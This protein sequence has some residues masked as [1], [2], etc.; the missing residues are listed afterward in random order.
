MTGGLSVRD[1]TVDFTTAQGTVRACSRVSFDVE[2]GTRLAI[3]GESG[4]GKTTT[5]LALLGM[6][7][8]SARVASG[9]A[10]LGGRDILKLTGEV[11]RTVRLAE[12][13]YVPQGAMNSLNP[14]LRIQEQILHGFADH[15]RRLSAR[16]GDSRIAELLAMVGLAPSVAR[17]FPHQLSGG[18]KQRVCIAI[19]AS[20]RPGLLIADEPTS[21]LDVITQRQVMEALAAS[22]RALGSGM[23]LIAHDVALVGQFADRVLVLN[24][25]EV[26]EAGDV[27]DV[28]SAPRQAYTR[29]LIESVPRLGAPGPA[30]LERTRAAGRAPLL[31]FRSV[32]KSYAGAQ[33]ASPALADLSFR[34]SGDP[35]GVLAVVGQSGSG[36]T[37]LASLALGL[38]APDQGVIRYL[39]QPLADLRGQ[40]RRDFRREVQAVFQDPYAA[41]NPFYRVGRALT[42]PLRRFGAARSRSHAASLA[43]S[44]CAEVG[45]DPDAVLRR[46]PHEL[47]G[48]QRQRLMVARALALRPR[49][50]IADE[51][52]S[53][54]DASLRAVILRNLAALRERHGVSVIYITHDLVT[55]QMIADDVIVL[56]HGVVVEA[57]RAHSVIESPRHPYTRELVAAIPSL[58]LGM[59]WLRDQPATTR[60]AFD[61]PPVIRGLS[62]SFALDAGEAA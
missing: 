38:T 18:M 27:R 33:A 15:G 11:Q 16:E 54:V 1:L 41:F 48:G 49:L 40:A 25:G 53:M 36:K 4:S 5:A 24:K 9:S 19:A 26:I 29:M 62:P 28:L 17:M 43:E 50:L 60:P 57:G 56:H 10:V 35:V 21:A 2:P 22:Q 37:T 3:V 6:L 14:V 61:A 47:S 30:L 12:V 39:G 46:Y 42:G 58:D 13:S 51:P 45:L 8:S 59:P 52:V 44:A 23:I 31:E 32:A 34:L 20:L 55:A 7:P